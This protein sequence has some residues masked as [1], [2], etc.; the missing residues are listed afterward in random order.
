[1]LCLPYHCQHGKQD[2]CIMISVTLDCYGMF[3]IR[4][5]RGQEEYKWWT[6]L[7]RKCM[8]QKKW[9]HSK[10]MHLSRWGGCKTIPHSGKFGKCKFSYKCPQGLQPGTFQLWTQTNI[11]LDSQLLWKIMDSRLVAIQWGI[12]TNCCLL[13]G[14]ELGIFPSWL[15]LCRTSHSLVGIFYDFRA[16]GCRQRSTGIWK[17]IQRLEIPA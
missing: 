10:K 2:N 16:N 13:L 7:I 15:A 3:L 4:Q 12:L 5:D 6:C 11:H 9:C 17:A 1:M 14:R 8:W